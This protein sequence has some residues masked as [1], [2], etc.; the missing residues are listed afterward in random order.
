MP[1]YDRIPRFG[2][3]EEQIKED[4]RKIRLEI[5]KELRQKLKLKYKTL[6]DNLIV[7]KEDS[8]TSIESLK[9]EFINIFRC[10]ENYKQR[11]FAN[12]YDSKSEEIKFLSNFMSNYQKKLEN[13]KL[14]KYTLVCQVILYKYYKRI[15]N[16]KTIREF[17][18][19]PELLEIYKMLLTEELKYEQS[20]GNIRFKFQI[21]V[22]NLKKSKTDKGMIK[23]QIEVDNF[24]NLEGREKLS[25]SNF[26]FDFLFKYN[27]FFVNFGNLHCNLDL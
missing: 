24:Q 26:L 21:N 13:G 1:K 19:I 23:L 8:I 10:I 14:I 16:L 12:S 5:E 15:P 7:E 22:S 17:P 2:D 25:L 20:R 6:I 11:N 9:L 4:L 3:I 27:E 18:I